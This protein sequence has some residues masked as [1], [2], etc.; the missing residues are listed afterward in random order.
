MTTLGQR[1]VKLREQKGLKQSELAR[2]AQIPLSTLN[3]IER[4]VR[5]GEGLSVGTAKKIAKALGVTLD[6]LVGMYDE[7]ESDLLPAGVAM[8]GAYDHAGRDVPVTTGTPRL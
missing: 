1:V 7:D 5:K 3:M 4:G 6:Y 2:L 8:V